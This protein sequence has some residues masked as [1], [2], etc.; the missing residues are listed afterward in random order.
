MI[1]VGLLLNAGTLAT[2]SFGLKPTADRYAEGTRALRQATLA[3]VNQETGL[4]A[5]LLTGQ[6]PFLEPYRDGLAQLPGLDRTVRTSFADAPR[7]LALLDVAAVAAGDWIQQWAAVAVER[8]PELSSRGATADDVAFI[9]EGKRLFDAFRV[10]ELAAEVHADDLEA[11]ATDRESQVLLA[12]IALQL[13]LLVVGAALIRREVRRLSA[14]VVRPVQSLVEHISTLGDQ[15]GPAPQDGPEELRQIAQGLNEMSASLSSER[16][17]VRAREVDLVAARQEAESATVAKSAFLATMSHEIRT[18][19]NAVIG[20]TSLLLDTPLTDEQRDYAETVRSSGDA[21]LVIINDVLDFSK[22]ESGHLELERQPFLLR[23]CVESALDLVAAQAADQGLELNYQIEADV[24]AVVEGDVTRLRQVLV[25]LLGNAVKFTERGEVVITVSTAAVDGVAHTSFAVADTGIGIPED[26]MHRLFQSFSQVDASTTRTHGGTG[27]GLAISARLATAMGGSLTVDSTP[28]LGSTF[29]LSAPLPA[30]TGAH[31]L[32]RV[33]PAELPGKTAL[34]LDDNATNRRILRS[35]LEAWGMVVEVD[36]DP[37][38]TV[39]RAALRSQPY[40]VVL[41]D[42]HMPHLDGVSVAT[43]LRRLEG[44][45]EVPLVLLTSL[46]QRPAE[47]EALRLIHLTKP[48]KAMT[49]RATLAHALGAH[50]MAQAGGPSDPGLPLLRILVAEDNVVNQKVATLLLQ[51]LGQQ[52]RVVSHGAEA[53]AAV[54]A[55][56][57]DLVLMD[58]LMPVMDGLQAT[59][60]IREQVPPDRQPRIVAMTANV[61][62]EDREACF[63]AGMDDYLSKPVRLDD[64][65]TAVRRVA[66]QVGVLD[67]GPPELPE[68]PGPGGEPAPAAVDPAV[69]VALT[70]R[71]GDRAEGFRQVLIRTFEEE[72]AVRLAELDAAVAAEDR[73]GVS[74][75]A[76]T[77]KSSSAA[78]GALVLAAWCEEV[79][80]GLRAG[81]PR[82]LSADASRIRHLLGEAQA[83]LHRLWP[84]AS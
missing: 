42:M 72:S 17:T 35:Q 11:R 34:V 26:R 9:A 62:L 13:L 53:L 58:V 60:A 67:G 1:T 43:I 16:A 21:L 3:L 20:M 33:A 12:S 66:R 46:G 30:G 27:L 5:Y 40:D 71:L 48:V 73:D 52:P 15:P 79:E 45:S 8:G 18:P 49:L 69:L 29:V 64:L 56:T 36:A 77:L 75:V 39:Q 19:M 76:H 54:Q 59:R 70:E 57:F 78:L 28:G 23:D 41:L 50:A 84:A 74:R 80:G 61:L 44:W 55:D 25:N 82:D 47:T 83:E 31:D 2:I 68:T 63:A 38:E 10:A 7:E 65:T 81:A 22:I 51:R 32:L 6:D 37:R 24:P 14:L 4:R